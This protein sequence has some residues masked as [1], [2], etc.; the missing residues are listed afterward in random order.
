MD[1]LGSVKSAHG[2]S[3]SEAK[4]SA[5]PN[6]SVRMPFLARL[7]GHPRSAQ[8]AEK[9]EPKPSFSSV[10]SRDGGAQSL[11]SGVG[12]KV[13]ELSRLLGQSSS[14][15]RH[16]L[17]T[18]EPYPWQTSCQ[19]GGFAVPDRPSHTPYRSSNAG[20]SSGV[21]ADDNYSGGV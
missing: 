12:G 14:I 4:T 7:L 5:P 16:P 13:S 21:R 2:S 10:M 15:A 20:A 3:V 9:N 1:P 17:A 6:Q 11:S 18:P 19:P 8:P